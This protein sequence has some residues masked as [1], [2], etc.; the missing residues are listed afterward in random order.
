MQGDLLFLSIRDGAAGVTLLFWYDC[1]ELWP[2]L[3]PRVRP[4]EMRCL[5][6]F[7]APWWVLNYSIYFLSL[8][9]LLKTL[10]FQRATA[11]L[12]NLLPHC[13]RIW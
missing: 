1:F 6:G 10:I 4:P 5:L 13:Y 7:P 3:P 12:L 11:Y 2:T 9:K 8:A